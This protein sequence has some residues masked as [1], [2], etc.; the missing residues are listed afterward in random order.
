MKLRHYEMDNEE[1]EI[2]RQLCLVLK[3]SLVQKSCNLSH[4]RCTYQ[5]FKDATLFFSRDGIPNIATVIP[6][7]DR[8]DEVLASSA[9]DVQFSVSIKAA[10]ALGKKTL[11]RYYSKT[12]MSDV[13]RTAMSK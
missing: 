4:S 12:D 7:M 9:L 2:A 3:V 10:L 5:I 11:N 1:W 13:Y 8:I 6:A